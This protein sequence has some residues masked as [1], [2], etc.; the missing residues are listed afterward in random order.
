M[1]GKRRSWLACVAGRW[2]GQFTPG[3][4]AVWHDGG[5]CGAACRRRDPGGPGA[6]A[7]AP[8]EGA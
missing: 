7:A 6:A 4:S 1:F 8:R 2:A 5:G 3:W